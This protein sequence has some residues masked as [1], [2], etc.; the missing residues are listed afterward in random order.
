MTELQPPSSPNS[1]R[2]Y[3]D[4]PWVGVG[5]VV[6]QDDEI[7]LIRRGR[8][9]RKGEWGIPGGAQAVG[10]TVFE[11]AIREVREEAGVTIRP[12]TIITAVDS[13]WR[14]GEGRVEF[15]YTLVEV[16]AEWT[17]GEAIA[18]SDAEEVC[19]VKPAAAIKL[20]KWDETL[21]VIAEAARLRG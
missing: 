6:W 12:T 20:V 15:H 1:A 3:P 2:E 5:V 7:L 4:R 9:P 17:A 19:W 18:A 16:S 11:A 10:E 13:I 8:P 14:D 21:R